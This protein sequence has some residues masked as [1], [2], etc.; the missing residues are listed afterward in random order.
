MSLDPR[1]IALQGIGFAPLAVAALGLVGIE[2][3]PVVQPAGGAFSNR[4]W[5]DIPFLPVRPRRPRK[6]RQEELLFLGH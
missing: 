6:K 1:A 5:R 2:A 3:P 4:P